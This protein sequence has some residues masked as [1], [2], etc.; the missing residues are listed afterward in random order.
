[1]PASAIIN[2][3]KAIIW[4]SAKTCPVLLSLHPNLIKTIRMNFH[5]D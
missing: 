5:E 4:Q 2:Y 3:E 1:M